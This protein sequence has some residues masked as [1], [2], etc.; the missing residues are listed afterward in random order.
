MASSLGFLGRY[1]EVAQME[2][3]IFEPKFKKALDQRHLSSASFLTSLGAAAF[4]LNQVDAAI[5]YFCQAQ[6]INPYSQEI[7]NNVAV[8][9]KKYREQFPQAICPRFS[10][11]EDFLQVA[12]A[13]K[14]SARQLQ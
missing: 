3:L 9:L 6:A 7:E 13:V 4:F 8:S 10:S 1:K 5:L 14:L 2:S 11:T 12:T